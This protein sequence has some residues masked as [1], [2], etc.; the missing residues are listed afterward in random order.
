MSPLNQLNA[1]Y[2]QLLGEFNVRKQMLLTLGNMF[3]ENQE[4]LTQLTADLQA[5]RDEFAKLQQV[6][7]EPVV[8]QTKEEA[9]DEKPAKKRGKKK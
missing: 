7:V 3:K 9:I 8:E 2:Q 4:K 6:Q 1:K 5:L